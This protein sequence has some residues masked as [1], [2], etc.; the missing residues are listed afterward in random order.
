M[1]TGYISPLARIREQPGNGRKEVPVL[2][3]PKCVFTQICDLLRMLLSHDHSAG[4]KSFEDLK[5]VNGNH[6]CIQA[7]CYS[8]G[9]LQDDREWEVV[10]Q[11][12]S[13]FQMCPQL[14]ELFVTIL[15]F[16]TVADPGNIFERF[17]QQCWDD[18][19]LRARNP[20]DPVL[21]RTLVLCDIERRLQVS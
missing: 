19:V 9:L 11:E 8:L 2:S 3:A 14:R 4:A 16:C 18:Y 13:H 10:L 21:L 15:Q 17:H 12:A 7:T 1:A 6:N 5:I 20:V